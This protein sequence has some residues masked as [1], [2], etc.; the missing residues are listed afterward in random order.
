MKSPS[1]VQPQLPELD[2]GNEVASQPRRRDA[3]GQPRFK[4]YEVGRD[5]HQLF[6]TNVF[7]LLPPEHDCFVFADLLAQLDTQEVLGHYSALGQ[8]AYDPRQLIGILIYSYARGVF[9]SRQIEQRCREDLGFRFIAG[10]N[11]PNFRVLSDFRKTHGALLKSCFVQTVQL[12]LE[13]NLASLAHVSLDGSKFKANSSKHKAMSYKGLKQREK[14]LCDEIEAL[15]KQAARA[16]EQEDQQYKDRTGYE[17]PEDLAFK[18]KRLAKIK[19]AKAQLEAREH[20]R[21]GDQP[22]DDKKQISFADYDANIMSKSGHVQYAYNAQISVDGDWQ[23]I[24]GQHVSGLANDFGEVAQALDELEGSCG[25]LPQK[26]S[27]DNGYYSGQNLAE[28]EQRDVQAYV[29]THREDKAGAPE[30]DTRPLVKADFI[31]NEEGDFFVCPN[32]QRLVLK[33]K[34]KASRRLYGAEDEACSVC[35]LKPRCC[36]SAQGKGRTLTCDDHEAE[37]RR[38]VQRMEQAESKQLYDRRKVI[39]EPVFGQIKNNGFNSFSLRGSDKVAG[40]FSLAS[41]A[42]NMKKFVRA[43]TQGLIHSENSKWVATEV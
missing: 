2:D 33:R 37:R 21:H 27:L 11:C 42:H 6:A 26:M 7:E 12:A 20:Q 28:L 32:D 31:Y 39:V 1:P 9:S 5:Q 40:E 23:I 38:M 43:A 24:V 36:Q 10:S 15:V 8:R 17:V 35:P 34:G 18:E 29:A 3:S 30:H 22:I 25:T 14:A 41:I 13:L 19:E 4:D 16:D